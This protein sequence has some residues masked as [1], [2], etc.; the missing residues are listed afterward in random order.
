MTINLLVVEPTQSIRDQ[1]RFHLHK[2]QIALS[3]LYSAAQLLSRVELECPSAILLR[4]ESPMNQAREALRQLRLAGYD[5]PIF[6]QSTSD[7][8]VDKIV[9]FELGADDYIVDPVDPYELTARIKRAV[10]RGNRS[11]C[12]APEIREKVLF[13]NYQIDFATRRLLKDGC[14]IPLR[15]GQF[16]LLKLFASNPMRILTRSMVHS[17][18]G[19]AE[20]QHASLD[21]AVCRLRRVIEA[22]PTNPK[23]IQTLR[24]RGY[25]F[26]PS[27]E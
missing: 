9:A 12:D 19:R 4:A 24:G 3:V 23:F 14:E 20:S 11:L 10:Q 5:M 1:L 7:E 25:M 21:V 17:Q 6:V 15:S 26:V 8:I 13:G 27:L 22:D 2:S 18:L 16:A